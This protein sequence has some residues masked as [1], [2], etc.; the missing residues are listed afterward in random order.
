MAPAWS[1]RLRRLMASEEGHDWLDHAVAD[2]GSGALL[3]GSVDLADQR[4]THGRR[5]GLLEGQ[6]MSAK[7]VPG[8]VSPPMTAAVA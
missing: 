8:T 4:D 5:T 1:M 6:R 3:L 2:E 7:I